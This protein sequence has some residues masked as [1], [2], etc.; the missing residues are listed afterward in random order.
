MNCIIKSIMSIVNEEIKNLQL[1]IAELEK[2]QQLEKEVFNKTSIDY[3]FSTIT[4]LLNSRKPHKMIGLIGL[5]NPKNSPKDMM[6]TNAIVKQL[7]AIYNI[8]QILDSRLSK[9]ENTK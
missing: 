3:N 8:L 6:N 2:E 1:R 4:E 5:C 9:I 7:E